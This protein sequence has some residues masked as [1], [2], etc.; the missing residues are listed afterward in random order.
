MPTRAVADIKENELKKLGEGNFLSGQKL[1]FP[2]TAVVH[3]NLSKNDLVEYYSIVDVNY[4]DVVLV[5]KIK[6]K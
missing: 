5:K 4:K 1:Y 6:R 2:K 3:L